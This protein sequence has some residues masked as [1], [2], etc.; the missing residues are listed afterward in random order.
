MGED[1]VGFARAGPWE[2][3]PTGTVADLDEL[4]VAP[5]HFRRGIGSRGDPA[6]KARA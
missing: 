4:Y 6:A 2:E 5:S 3:D 1:I